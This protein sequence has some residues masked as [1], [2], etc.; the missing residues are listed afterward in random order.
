MY[1]WNY[2]RGTTVTPDPIDIWESGTQDVGFK[3]KGRRDMYQRFIYQYSNKSF[4]DP[5]SNDRCERDN[6]VL[7]RIPLDT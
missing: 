6:N 5:D 4:G 1:R 7:G 3:N 2:H